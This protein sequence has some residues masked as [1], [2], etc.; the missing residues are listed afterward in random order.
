MFRGVGI[1]EADEEA[2]ALSVVCCVE[3]DDTAVCKC[4]VGYRGAREASQ[5]PFKF[6]IDGI[7]HVLIRTNHH[8]LTIGAVL[9][10][11]KHVRSNKG[12]R[13]RFIS[14]HHDFR[15]P[16]RHIDGCTLDADNLFGL[17]D[18]TVSRTEDFVNGTDAFR[19]VG[20]GTD[21]L[22]TTQLINC[23]DAAKLCCPKDDGV[24]FASF[25]ARCAEDDFGA[26]CQTSGDGK[27][28]DS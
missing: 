27:H 18:V 9:G 16:C 1:S 19:A 5:L 7:C 23:V 2:V 11:R 21:S 24:D 26:S 17:G 28:Q 13:C 12:G 22:R 15:R 3:N 6:G 20:H 25:V 10:L 14:K 4:L 8:S